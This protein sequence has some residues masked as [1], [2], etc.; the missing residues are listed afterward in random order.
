MDFILNYNYSNPFVLAV[1]SFVLGML[2]MTICR[3]TANCT[4]SMAMALMI[5]P[6]LVTVALM[7]INGSLGTSVA[8]LGVFS[9]VRFRSVP[10]SAKD[11]VNV[12]Y[13]MVTGLLVS[14]GY[15][16]I[17]VGVVL[18]IGLAQI[19]VFTM[20]RSH[21]EQEYELKILVPETM[22]FEEVF[23][24]IIT[25]YFE[26]HE[27]YQIKTTNMGALFEL[28]YKGI[29]KKDLNRKEMMDEIRTHNGN[30]TV[31]YYKS[32]NLVEIL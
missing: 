32:Q 4:K 18:I 10:G 14:T 20:F 1:L 7:A 11:I 13:A 9:L 21:K 22:N 24:D 17:A 26:K 15:V 19:I 29:P 30:L 6:P 12:F 16:F 28:N 5:L 3:K 23:E 31:S 25:K 27:L 2:I 8:I